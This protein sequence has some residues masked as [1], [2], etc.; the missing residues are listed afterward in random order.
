MGVQDRCASFYYEKVAGREAGKSVYQL[1]KHDTAD[2]DFEFDLAR[3]KM[4]IKDFDFTDMP[5]RE[6]YI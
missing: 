6:V 4:Y 2:D 5:E 3:G 1:K